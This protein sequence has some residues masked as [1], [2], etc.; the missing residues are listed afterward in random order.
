M[1]TAIPIARLLA[2]NLVHHV[3]LVS[4]GAATARARVSS[5]RLLVGIGRVD[6]M[7]AR[8]AYT[9]IGHPGWAV[10]TAL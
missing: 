1:L 4:M 3:R 6:D 2:M 9:T 7:A 5:S 8:A 10:S